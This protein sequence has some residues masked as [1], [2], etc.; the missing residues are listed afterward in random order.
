MTV[1]Q[2]L[3]ERSLECGCS[4]TPFL[5]ASVLLSASMGLSRSRLLAMLPDNLSETVC[6]DSLKIFETIWNRRCQGESV[7]LIL[8]TKEFFGRDFHIDGF[9]L[10]PRPDTETLVEAAMEIGDDMEPSGLGLR[11]HDLCTGSGIVAITL[12]MERRSW[13]VSA[14]DISTEALAVAR[15][16]ID[17]IAGFDIPLFHADLFEGIQGPFDIVTANPP[18]VPHEETNELL[19]RGWK[20]PRLAL[21]GGADGFDVIERLIPQS[22]NRLRSGGFLLIETDPLQSAK[23]C[24]I[25]KNEGFTECRVW[26][27]LAG[28][29]RVTGARCP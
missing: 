21:D 29:A 28:R 16:N 18:Y 12:A 5:D 25:L 10:S 1:R 24:D 9:V 8:G 15:H 3:A 27:D 14:S 4:E 2:Y 23:T 20:E 19:A 7:A 17:S 13:S 26:K 22:R 6:N 11:I